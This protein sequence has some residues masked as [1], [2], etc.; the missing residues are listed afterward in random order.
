MYTNYISV[1]FKRKNKS[2]KKNKISR[3]LCLPVTIH[4]A[5]PA[6][7]KILTQIKSSLNACLKL[8]QKTTIIRI[9][10]LHSS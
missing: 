5:T 10:A 1:I 6:P 8:S 4:W 3:T 7:K 9:S 2:H